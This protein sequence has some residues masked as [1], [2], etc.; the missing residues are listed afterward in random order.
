MFEVLANPGQCAWFQCS[1]GMGG[2]VHVEKG[3]KSDNFA[4]G[5]KLRRW[6]PVELHE[7]HDVTTVGD[8]YEVMFQTHQQVID[9][10][11]DCFGLDLFDFADCETVMLATVEKETPPTLSAL[12]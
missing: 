2:Q 8:G 5:R 1:V 12:L 9:F 3:L 4:F 7:R 11:R 10:C 6:F